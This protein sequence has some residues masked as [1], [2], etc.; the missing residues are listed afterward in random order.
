M[1][2]GPCRGSVHTEWQEFDEVVDAG[3]RAADGQIVSKSI[4][5]TIHGIRVGTYHVH[6][7]LECC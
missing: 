5:P 6:T 1:I 3:I 2:F 4:A 7:H